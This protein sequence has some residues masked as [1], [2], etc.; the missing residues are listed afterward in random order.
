MP[1][2]KKTFAVIGL[3]EFGL[4]LA[5]ELVNLGQDVIAIDNKEENVERIS[6]IIDTVFVASGTDEIAL[7]ELGID[8]VD[9]AIVCIGENMEATIL[10]TVLLKEFNIPTILVRVDD[11]YYI[12]I[13]KKLGA[14]EVISPQRHAG[15]D[16]A[17]RLVYEDYR[18]YYK[19]D[20]KYSIVSIVVNPNC[21]DLQIRNEFQ[22]RNF[23]VNVVL[24]VRDGKSF[25][26]TGQDFIKANDTIYV[27][28]NEKDIHD[29]RN[30]INEGKK[31][32]RKSATEY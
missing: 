28:G 16:F 29:F 23:G 12:P 26:P 10:T 11:N 5:T 3:G 21:E 15:R 9:V 14:T 1:T 32:H 13:I 6:Q 2:N 24:I 4:A 30:F 8:E 20:D 31:R 27:V 7:K 18:D 17:N 19:L 22:D 25:V